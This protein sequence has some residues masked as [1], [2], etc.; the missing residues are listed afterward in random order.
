MKSF[1]GTSINANLF[2]GIEGV[3]GKIHFSET[4]LVFISHAINI[5]RGKTEIIY[6]EIDS[7]ST[8]NTLGILPNGVNIVLN[9]G[10]KYKFVINNRSKIIDFLN[11]QI[12]R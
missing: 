2:R 6:N 3:G 9:N 7:V 5:Q 1:I 8:R 4:G 12:E 10:V 11:V